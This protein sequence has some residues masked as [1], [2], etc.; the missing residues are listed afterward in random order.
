LPDH[1]G[2]SEL[3]ISP[4]DSYV[5][6]QLHCLAGSSPSKVGQFSFEC[7]LWFRR[8]ALQSTAYPALEVAC[9]CVRLLGFLRWK[10]I[11]LPC[12]LSL[13]QGVFYPPPPQSMFYYSSLF[14]FQFFGVVRFWM[15]L[16]G[17]GDELCDPPHALIQ[18][19]AY[20]PPAL[21]L[22][23]FPALVC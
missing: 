9:C 15:L 17:S 2:W 14:V 12:L 1:A 5:T 22:P 11:S 23:A 20:C 19:V 10:F 6:L 8:S 21:G 13:G 16:T 18:G 4:A 3:L 7:N